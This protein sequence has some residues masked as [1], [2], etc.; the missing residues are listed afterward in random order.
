MIDVVS[1]LCEDDGCTKRPS[2]N[3]PRENTG[4]FCKKHMLH[5]MI[6]VANKRCEHDGCTKRPSYNFPGENKGRFCKT[7]MLHGMIDVVSKR[8]EDDGC[9]K[10]PVYNYPGENTGRLCKTHMLHGMIDVINKQ[11]QLCP[12][13][14]KNKK[15]KGYCY[16]CFIHMF[17]DNTIV[18]NHKTKERAVADVIRNRFSHID[19]V[20][21]KRIEG[22]CSNRRPD[23]FIDM[24][25]H[26]VVIEID[27]EQHQSY[28]CTCENKRLM[29]LFTDC[30]S[31]PFVM[32]RFNPDAYTDIN[33][34]RHPSCWKY[35]KNGVCVVHPK[36]V[37]EWEKRLDTLCDHLKYV[38]ESNAIQR[39]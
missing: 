8:C 10:Q 1:K 9:T 13:I 26:V 21:D 36:H 31:R 17:P 14:A 27:E 29:E 32:I 20:L 24:G 22:G 2:Y 6:D 35:T 25:T 5:G 3:F 18:R 37:H 33:C 28:D 12:T 30:G 4:R 16:R 34:L 11:C 7:H 15:Y 39:D 38:C 23:I 19:V